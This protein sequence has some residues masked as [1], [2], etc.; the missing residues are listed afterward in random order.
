MENAAKLTA[1]KYQTPLRRINIRLSLCLASLL[2][3]GLTGVWAAGGRE[4]IKWVRLSSRNGDLP[5]P[6]EST[7]QTGSLVADLDKDGVSDF[8]ISFRVVAPALVWYQRTAKGWDRYVIEKE[9]LTVEAGGAAHDIDGDGDLDI[10]FGGDSQSDQVWW[11]ENPAPKFEPNV[12]WKRRVI[13]TGG[14]KQH[15]DQVFGDFK[16]TGKTQLAFWNQGAKTI[17]LADIPADPRRAESW[18]MTVI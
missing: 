15:H 8:V 11:W 5:A 6:G 14:A 4:E 16:G 13:K 9:F 1:V 7:Q 10:V 17:F 18:P 3:I 12:S 2:A